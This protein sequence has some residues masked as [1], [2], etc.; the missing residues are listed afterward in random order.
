MKKRGGVRGC[1]SPFQLRYLHDQFTEEETF[2][3]PVQFCPQLTS[4][5]LDTPAE[6]VLARLK[7]F[8]QLR[9]LKFNKVPFP[10]VV[11]AARPLGAQVS[12]VEARVSNECQRRFH[13]HGSQFTI[14]WLKATISIKCRILNNLPVRYFLCIGIT[15]PIFISTYLVQVPF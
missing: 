1:S 2:D 15:C 13:N 10:A 11:E 5:F 8:P 6:A 14:S 7:E 12:A 3:L 4:I 9:R